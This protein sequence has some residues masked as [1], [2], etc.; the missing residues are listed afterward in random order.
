MKIDYAKEKSDE[1]LKRDGTYK[2]R[3]RK[4]KPLKMEPK[5]KK[6]LK[7]E[8]GVKAHK[9][10]LHPHHT[11]VVKSIPEDV[12]KEILDGLFSKYNGLKYNAALRCPLCV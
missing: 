9:E 2:K 1:T 7:V 8:D 6:K 3:V 4:K 11:L 12:D 5:I 10:I